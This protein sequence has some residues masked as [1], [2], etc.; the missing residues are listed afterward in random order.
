MNRQIVA[1]LLGLTVAGCAFDRS[2]GSRSRGPVPTVEMT[3]PMP[4]I[5]EAINRDNPRVDPSSVRVGHPAEIPAR[6]QLALKTRPAP[7]PVPTEAEVAA[8]NASGS[9]AR[10]PIAE[11][12]IRPVPASELAPISDPEDPAAPTVPATSGDPLP[13]SHSSETQSPAPPVENAAPAPVEPSDGRVPIILPRENSEVPRTTLEN[14]GTLPAVAAPAPT[15]VSD[16]DKVRDPLLGSDPD[17]MPKIELPTTPNPVKSK[18]PAAVPDPVEPAPAPSPAPEIPTT[19]PAVVNGAPAPMEPQATPITTLPAVVHGAPAPVEP[20]ATPVTALPA[21]VHGSPAPV[22]HPATPVTTGEQPTAPAPE[23]QPRPRPPVVGD[24]LLGPDPDIMPLIEIN[25]EVKASRKSN[26]APPVAP[27]TSKN[28]DEN[29]SVFDSP[30]AESSTARPPALLP[31]APEVLTPS[32]A[33]EPLPSAPQARLTP[34]QEVPRLIPAATSQSVVAADGASHEHPKVIDLRRIRDADAV[35]QGRFIPSTTDKSVAPVRYESPGKPIP[36]ATTPVPDVAIEPLPDF[37]PVPVTNPPGPTPKLEPA[38]LPA[39]TRK[40]APRARIVPS[41]PFAE[42]VELPPLSSRDTSS[43]LI[44]RGPG[45]SLPTVVRGSSD[46]LYDPDVHRAGTNENPSSSPGPGPGTKDSS[47]IKIPPVTRSIFEAGK[48]VARVG[49]EVITTHELKL[50]VTVRRRGMPADRPLSSEENYMLAKTVLNDLIDR[51]V[52]IQEAKRQLK[53]P[54]QLQMFMDLANRIWTEEELPPLLRQ[55]SS[56]NIYELKEKLSERGESIEDIREQFR[57]EFLSRGFLE[58][59]IG[60]KLQVGL[61][62]MRE[63]YMAHLDNFALPA[64]VTW[65]E[66][67][68][69]VDKHKFRAEAKARADAI[70]N[71]LRHGEDFARL[72]KAESD[73]PNKGDGGLWSTSPGSY[74][75]ASVN[76]ATTSLPLG[77][78]SQ[79]I[80]GP[81]SYHVIRVE[82]RRPAGPASF[83]D[84]QD[85]I[86]RVIRS[87]KIHKESTAYLEKLRG[88]TV[89]TSV[90]DDPG[91]RRASGE[92][93]LSGPEKP[94]VRR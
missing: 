64:Q 75:V 18:Q 81:T 2:P 40:P 82:A 11:T 23:L 17:I 87:E 79:V 19:L 59:K 36:L 77:Q 63:Y 51:S 7:A 13:P 16:P 76:A 25:Q 9:A 22:E 92:T 73:G 62:E 61:P 8:S 69:E 57:Q 49:E 52:V 84:V 30:G 50:A 38:P 68:V 66:V 5:H 29:Q 26:P 47:A 42:P 93:K 24:P 60:P 46:P 58:Q 12:A 39:P 41:D 15:S 65:R 55:T 71:R 48:P 56:T 86:R 78:I 27:P 91:V 89:I 53:N 74:S 88:N 28:R 43:F 31:P 32:P 94:P 80:E 72:A 4:S 20:R 35:L 37:E 90:F 44:P 21:V 70:L 67:L 6:P 10:G 14:S 85:K 33:P 45:G 83:G 54:K 3:P 1:G 34:V